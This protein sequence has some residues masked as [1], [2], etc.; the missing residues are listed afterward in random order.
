MKQTF[1]AK[2]EQLKTSPR[3]FDKNFLR[4]EA[5]RLIKEAS[6]VGEGLLHDKL[7]QVDEFYL[8]ADGFADLRNV[9]LKRASLP[10]TMRAIKAL[11]K[12]LSI[13]KQAA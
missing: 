8:L 1:K 2:V 13:Y 6:G 4:E 5:S 10:V 3:E 7:G 12:F 11:E 9:R